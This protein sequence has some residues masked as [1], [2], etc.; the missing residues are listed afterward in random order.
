ML[1]G[2]YSKIARVIE[3]FKD[4]TIAVV[5]IGISNLSVI[6]FLHNYGIKVTAFDRKCAEELGESYSELK[7]LG[8]RLVLGPE[9]LDHL[10]EFDIIFKTPGLSPNAPQFQ[11]ALEKGALLMSEMQLFFELCDAPIVAVTGSDGKTTTTTLIGR[12]CEEAG[13]DVFVGGNIGTPPL[14]KVEELSSDSI[15]ILELSSFQLQVMKRS[16]KVAVVLNVTPNHLDVHASMEEYIDAKKNIYRYHGTKDY[17]IFNYDNDITRAMAEEHR[18]QTLCYSLGSE[19]LEGAFL[20][21]TEIILRRNHEERVVMDMSDIRLR[22]MHNIS[23]VLASVVATDVLGISFE[24]IR[25][26][27]R[28]FSGVEHRIEF[29][30][31]L[32]GVKYFNDSIAT[33]PA[34]SIAGINAFD[35]P[36]ILIA[37]GSDKNIDFKEFAEVVVEKVKTLVLMG[38]TAE[39]I[40]NAVN[41]ASDRQG[42]EIPI[43]RCESFKEAIETAHANA[44]S[45]D[46]VLLSPACAS[47]DMFESYVE[48]GRLFKELVKEL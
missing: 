29:V 1:L 33:S 30:R 17:G 43:L 26:A 24:H 36:V 25:D 47:F 21:G 16:P 23:N 9:Y 27:V 4:K 8:T 41:Y 11:A 28:A 40:E 18:G 3:G 38:S 44:E 39:K 12:I 35:E 19:V 45:G 6:R 14:D 48:R 2:D 7:E 42:R 5:G 37:G 32:D 46:V 34:R 31:E 15:V 10:S 20:K 13:L 22:G